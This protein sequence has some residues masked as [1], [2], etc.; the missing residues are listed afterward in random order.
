MTKAEEMAVLDRAI[1]ALGSDSYLGPWL[2]SVRC[3]AER[4]MLSD[5]SVEAFGPSLAAALSLQK[6]R[7]V[8][9][10]VRAEDLRK[11]GYQ[12]GDRERAITSRERWLT[13]AV[14]READKARDALRGIVSMGVVR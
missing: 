12:L 1:A 7:A 4:E 2:A 3:D 8:E 10:D 6:A 11:L 13:D 5:H 14:N 9:L